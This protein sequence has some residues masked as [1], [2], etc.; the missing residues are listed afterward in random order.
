MAFYNFYKDKFKFSDTMMDLPFV[1]PH[2]SL[3]YED[4]IGLEKTVTVDEIKMAIWDCCSQKAPGPDGRKKQKLMI[5]KVDFEKAFD[6]VSWKYLDH[7]LLS[8]GFGCK[9][10]RWIHMCLHS[11]R[12]S[13][14]VNGSPTSEFSI[15]RGLRQGD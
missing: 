4:N 9:W 11:A 2:A 10:R 8:L 3:N 14:L 5:F 6:T 15:K 1:I 12:A 13:V 7:M